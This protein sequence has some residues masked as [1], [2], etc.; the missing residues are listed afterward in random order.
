MRE[1]PEFGEFVLV[2]ALDDAV[3]Y[4][5]SA[6]EL[7]DALRGMRANMAPAG[8]LMFDVNTLSV[9]RSFF[10]EVE[11]VE[12]GGRYLVW[13]GPGIAPSVPPV[14]SVKLA[15][16]S[17]VSPTRRPRR[18][19]STASA[20]SPKRGCWPCLSKPAWNACNRY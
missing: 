1:L 11:R 13:R 12:R 9:Y 7:G 2:W 5:L 3:N 20:T 17:K 14:R 6:D 16:K 10:V 15:S 18:P 4:L 19:T 8:L